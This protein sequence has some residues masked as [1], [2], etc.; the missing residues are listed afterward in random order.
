MKIARDILATLTGLLLLL[1]FVFTT[2]QWFF[3]G[4]AVTDDAFS[5]P[6]RTLVQCVEINATVLWHKMGRII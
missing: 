4:K 6:D 2:L 5:R 3:D 1:F